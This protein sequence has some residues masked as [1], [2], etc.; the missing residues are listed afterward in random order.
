M[1]PPRNGPSRRLRLDGAICRNRWDSHAERH[2]LQRKFC[3]LL[4]GCTGR[5]CDEPEPSAGAWGVDTDTGPNTGG[6]YEAWA[7]LDYDNNAQFAVVAEPGTFVLLAAGG[8][9]LVPVIRRRRRR[10]ASKKA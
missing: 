10:K 2:R 8:L 6:Q 4:G 9:A 5:R 3:Q 7:V 1:E